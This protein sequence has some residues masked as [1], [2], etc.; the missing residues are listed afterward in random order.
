MS[1]AV[2]ALLVALAALSTAFYI[3]GLWD[4]PFIVLSSNILFPAYALISAIFGFD[5]AR[6]YGFRSFFGAIFFLLALGLLIWC[7]GEIM[8]AIYVLV[9]GIEVP[10]PSLADVFYITGYGS[11][12][13]GFFIFMKVFGHVFSERAIKVPSIISGLVI[14]A[15][16]SFTVVPEALIHSGNIVEAALAVAYPMH[17]AVLIALAVIAL[18]VFWGG[19][20]ARGWLYLLIGFM[21]TGLVDIF[22]YYYDLLGLIW[23]G[24]PLELPWLLSYLAIAKG[25][26]DLWIGRE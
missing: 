4:Q 12:F 23:E 15:I 13:I 14:L 8:W 19:K 25:F 22:Y 10:F 9:L 6:R 17:D 24:H 2:D 18:M 7:I 11:F 1:K 5:V 20:L 21:L 3:Y 26:Y 16:T